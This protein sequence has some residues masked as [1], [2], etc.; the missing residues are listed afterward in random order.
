MLP[1]CHATFSR[2]Q[3]PRKGRAG[4]AAGEAARGKL[5]GPLVGGNGE[6]EA[7]GVVEGGE[8]GQETW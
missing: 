7:G 4:L 6:G 2:L 5:S 8:T 3:M 1:A